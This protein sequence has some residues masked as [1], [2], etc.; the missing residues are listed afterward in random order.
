[1]LV[2]VLVRVARYPFPLNPRVA[3]RPSAWTAVHYAVGDEEE[4]EEEEKRGMRRR[5]MMTMTILLVLM[6]PMMRMRMMM[7]MLSSW[8]V[9]HHDFLLA[10]MVLAGASV[11][12]PDY[13]HTLFTAMP[14]PE[15]W[16][17]YENT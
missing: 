16:L 11:V 13:L 12:L 9:A 15:P 10:Q 5:M 8:Q 7:L 3:A 2:R 1:V 17:L 6:M 14:S 4:K